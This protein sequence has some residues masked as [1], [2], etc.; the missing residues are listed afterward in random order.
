MRNAE[1]ILAIIRERGKRGL[2]LE[3]AYRLLFNPDLFLLAYANLY[4]NEGAMTKGI[5]GETVDGMSMGKIETLIKELR[6]E[7]YQPSPVRRTYIPK[8]NGKKRPLGIPTWRD[9]LV[10]EAIRL[11]L[12]AYYEPKFSPRSHGFRPARGCHTALTEVQRTWKGTVWFVE[13]DIRGCFDNIHHRVL[14]EIIH[15]DIHDG[16]F[17]ALI[18]KFLKAG[19][20][21]NWKYHQTYSGTPQGGVVSP[22]LSNIY[23]NEL[24][25]FVETELI[26]EYTKGDTRKSNKE[27]ERLR[28]RCKKAKARGDM[29]A[30]RQWAIQARA[31]PSQDAH[32]PNFKRLRY[33]R[34]ADDFLLGLIGS[35]EDAERIKERLRTFLMERLELEMSEEKTLVTH[36]GTNRAKFLG[37]EVGVMSSDSRPSVN[38]AIELRIPDAKINEIATRYQRNA[39]AHHRAEI[40]E[41]C[42][43]DIVAKYGA[44]WRGLVQYYLLARNVRR[45][46]KPER[47]IRLSLLKTLANNHKTTVKKVW[48]QFKFRHHT[49]NGGRMGLRVTVE[50]DGKEPL[51]AN[52]GEIPLIRRPGEIIGDHIN[53]ISLQARH[54]EIIQRLQADRC[55]VCGSK[56]QV[57]VH[58]VR[59][60]ADLI[61]K[62]QPERPLHVKI[63]AARRRKTLVVCKKCHLDIHS[64]RPLKKMTNAE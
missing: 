9:K 52:F 63:M 30:A 23:L 37:Y 10:Q 1:T 31:L 2:P 53:G 40:L 13:G 42:D 4:P 29:T 27:Y 26:P 34:Y 15:R 49:N 60:L 55:E 61:R 54:T 59:K 56:D 39:K 5:T 24:D 43:F 7:K 17:V 62:G 11:I 50:R 48:R 33:V 45:L 44:E 47:T 18:E 8:A 3:R 21:E 22:I 36:A 46:G 38:G 64:G 57:Q 12:D 32:D 16:R 35:K 20:L 58:H 19:Y 28:S 14:L 25:S 6:D 41:D 51:V